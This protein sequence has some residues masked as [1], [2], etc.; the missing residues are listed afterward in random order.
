MGS[1]ICVFYVRLEFGLD[2][3]FYE[4]RTS[5]RKYINT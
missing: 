3:N 1:F 4:G 5:T 2:E